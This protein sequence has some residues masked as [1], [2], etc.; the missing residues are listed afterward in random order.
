M[1]HAIQGIT[2]VIQY[3]PA[4]KSKP[5]PVQ[6]GNKASLWLIELAYHKKYTSAVALANLMSIVQVHAKNTSNSI[7]ET[8]SKGAG[9]QH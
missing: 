3:L 1:S 6:T 4:K 2:L 9:C 5:C 7:D 8:N